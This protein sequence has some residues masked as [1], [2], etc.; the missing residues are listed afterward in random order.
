MAYD[1]LTELVLICK[2]SSIGKNKVQSADTQLFCKAVS[3]ES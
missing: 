2:E 3:G 1:N